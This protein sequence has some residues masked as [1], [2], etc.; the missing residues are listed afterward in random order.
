MATTTSSENS[1]ADTEL[2]GSSRKMNTAC[3]LFFA[4]TAPTPA[5]RAAAPTRWLRSS[6]TCASS[7]FLANPGSC[8]F[9]LRGPIA[10]AMWTPCV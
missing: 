9:F 4:F 6:T 10:K 7:R 1:R 3:R 5:F 2:S 8:T